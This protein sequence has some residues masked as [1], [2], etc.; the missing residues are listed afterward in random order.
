MARRRNRRPRLRGAA[1]R[2]GREEIPLLSGAVHYW[3]LEPTHWLPAL[4]SLREMGLPLVETYVPWGEHERAPGE[5]DFGEGD[6]RL[7][8]RRFLEMAAE[9]GL[10]AIVRPGPCINAESTHFGI[11]E[12][13]VF[14]P[15][16]QARSPRQR[17]VLQP[18]PPRMFP[19]PSYASR[20]YHR[21]V[22]RWYE[23]VGECLAPLLWPDGPIVML[24][25]DNEAAFFFRDGPY[26]QDYHP[27]A[28]G[29]WAEFLADRY[30]DIEH[31]C[32]AHGEHLDT[33]EDARPPD[34]VPAGDALGPLCRA[35]DWIAF[36]EHLL[37]S[38]V[39]RLR[40]RMQR[41]GLHGV[42]TLHN[43]PLGEGGSPA[44]PSRMAREVDLVGL[45]YYHPARE[46]RSIKRRTLYLAGTFG[47]AAYAP[48]MGAGAPPWFLPLEHGDSFYTACCALAYGL[49][50]FNLYMAVDR[51]RWYGA[52]I[53]SDGVPRAEAADWARLV[54]ALHRVGFHTL[55]RRVDVALLVPREY[56]RLSQATHLPGL[57]SPSAFEAF[58]G[59]PVDGC[60]ERPRD[61][62]E[63]VQIAWWRW[64][65]LVSDTLTDI[66]VPYVYV[67]SEAPEERL[68]GYRLVC[69]P[70]FAFAAPARLETLRRATERGTRLLLGPRRPHLDDRLQ[71]L[72]PPDLPAEYLA[73]PEEGGAIPPRERVERLCTR[74]GLAPS[75]TVEPSPLEAT[76]H[77]EERGRPRVL[78]VLN[79]GTEAVE[80]RLKLP[81]PWTLRDMLDDSA[82]AASPRGELS[83]PMPGRTVR[84]L[85]VV[86]TEEEPS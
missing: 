38:A 33:W 2:L 7:D 20:A 19:I 21:E 59:T 62:G 41:A 28:V 73:L 61:L 30:E 10:R 85:E 53:G 45:D 18:F 47:S 39:A 11:P 51:D 29:A 83:L 70:L 76:L 48:E 27:D 49:R 77:E 37:A 50:G 5:F 52:P 82:W 86:R 64:L 31:L 15:A 25:V 55:R 44:S 67:D 16:C 17:P 58:G 43:V 12:R 42:P 57:L 60:D 34:R 84:L 71:P 1:L 65:A 63:P 32:R 74:L 36:R 24:Q 9:E 35:L 14:D 23:A 78:F 3:R 40:D 8:V 81:G 6:P 72:S 56:Q 80:S 69:S 26:E 46:H 68:V 75:L 54:R 22:G 4:R 79:P 66:Q 13:V